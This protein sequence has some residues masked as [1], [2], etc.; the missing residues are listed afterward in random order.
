MFEKLARHKWKIVLVLILFIGL[1]IHQLAEENERNLHFFGITEQI[2]LGPAGWHEDEKHVVI[3]D[4][5]TMQEIILMLK[6]ANRDGSSYAYTGF[7]DYKEEG[8]NSWIQLKVERS[9]P[10]EALSWIIWSPE[11][12]TVYVKP[13]FGEEEEG[14]KTGTKLMESLK[15][16]SQ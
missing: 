14:Y 6:R 13:L 7:S 4:A 12:D 5:D 15:K 3:N 16:L 2:E 1:G 11:M 10:R 8:G 9:L